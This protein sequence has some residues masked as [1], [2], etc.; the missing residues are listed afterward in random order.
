MHFD[1][2]YWSP[3]NQNNTACGMSWGAGEIP[4]VAAACGKTQRRG[5]GEQQGGDG[6]L[7]QMGLNPSTPNTQLHPAPP[8][9]AATSF[10]GI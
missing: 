9:R 2:L 6:A 7:V 5:C 10:A 8:A 1:T 3:E 4:H